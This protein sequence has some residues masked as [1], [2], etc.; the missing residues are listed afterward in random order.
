M[1]AGM[2]VATAGDLF[3]EMLQSLAESFGGLVRK[4]S[5][6]IDDAEDKILAGELQDQG[7]RLGRMRRTLARFRR[8]V[9]EP[10]RDRFGAAPPA[11]SSR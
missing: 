8:H 10:R 6:E 1:L 2:Q 11:P 4:L 7:A 3:D 9:R 5:D